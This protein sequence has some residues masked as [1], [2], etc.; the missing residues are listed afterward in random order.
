MVV[1]KKGL[2]REKYCSLKVPTVC[3]SLTLCFFSEIKSIS[4]L[5]SWL[6]HKTGLINAIE[7]KSLVRIVIV[8]G[9]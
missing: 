3:L 5:N 8:K 7:I 9:V 1:E 2:G 4:L 6:C